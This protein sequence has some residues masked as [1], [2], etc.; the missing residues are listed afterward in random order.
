MGDFNV[1]GDFYW[2][3][4]AL[5]FNLNFAAWSMSMKRSKGMMNAFATTWP[6]SCD[7]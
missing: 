6:I 5:T 7:P 1:V 3:F 4:V 2:H